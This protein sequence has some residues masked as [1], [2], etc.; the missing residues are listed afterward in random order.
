MSTEEQ[1]R[2]LV[3]YCRSHPQESYFDALTDLLKALPEF[4]FPEPSSNQ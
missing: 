3:A 2:H 1:E 4:E